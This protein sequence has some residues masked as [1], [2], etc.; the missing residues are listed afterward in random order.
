MGKEFTGKEF[1]G[2]EVFI[3]V[4]SCLALAGG[5]IFYGMQKNEDTLDEDYD[6]DKPLPELKDDDVEVEEPIK[7]RIKRKYGTN[8]NYQKSKSTTKRNRIR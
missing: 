2:K 8:R 3:G 1:S 5:L 7:P 6:E 4:A